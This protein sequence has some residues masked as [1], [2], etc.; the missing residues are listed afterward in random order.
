MILRTNSVPLNIVIPANFMTMDCSDETIGSAEIKAVYLG[1]HWVEKLRRAQICKYLLKMIEIVK[2]S[3]KY[4]L[5]I[6]FG[7]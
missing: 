3:K 2:I 5:S 7:D 4:Y 6:I 1:V